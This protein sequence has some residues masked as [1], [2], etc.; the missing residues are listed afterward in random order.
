MPTYTEK[1]DVQSQPKV[2]PK[3]KLSDFTSE[4]EGKDLGE[5]RQIWQD[6]AASECRM[7]LMSALKGKSLGFREIENFSLGLKY[8]FKSDKLRDQH[9]KPVEGVVK[10]AMQV[11]MIDEKQHHRELIKLRKIK[12]KKLSEKYHPHSHIHRKII[13]YLRQEAGETKRAHKEKYESKVKHLEK[14]YRDRGEEELQI[15]PS[16]THINH[17]SIFSQEKFCGIPKDELDV[18]RIGEVQLSEDE[19]SI[20]KKSPKFAIPQK[21]LEDSLKEEMEKAYSLVRIEL[22]EEEAPEY[23]VIKKVNNNKSLGKERAE[24]ELPKEGKATSKSSKEGALAV[25]KKQKKISL[26]KKRKPEQ[27]RCLTLY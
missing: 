13:R 16:M 26:K 17:L 15:P 3:L 20:L 9:D 14:V 25:V 5:L 22:R 24:K 21:L 2:N 10:A 27:G 11:K 4:I 6:I 1:G 18:P 8:S 23:Q 12:R 7:N 19:V